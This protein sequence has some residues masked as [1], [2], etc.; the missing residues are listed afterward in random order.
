V[1]VHILI[2]S[3]A[4]IYRERYREP[5]KL[6]V[7]RGM[8]D[9]VLW[10]VPYWH[11]DAGAAIMLILLSTVNEGLSAGFIGV[12]AQEA[13]RA[14][15]GIPEAYSITGLAMIG[16]RAN[17]ERRQGSVISRRRRPAGDVIHRERW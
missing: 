9:E 13:A 17:D 7:R 1:P 16:H 2:C 6:R 10:Q 3:S 12:W 15:L 4:D 5:D 14:Y 11:V 8:T